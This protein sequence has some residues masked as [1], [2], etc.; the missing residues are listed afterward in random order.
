MNPLAD[1]P[2]VL[3]L[4]LSADPRAWR[5][6]S[7]ACTAQDCVVLLGEAVLLMP[8]VDRESGAGFDCRLAVSGP[9]AEARGLTADMAADGVDFVDDPGLVTL[10]ATYDRCL[11]WR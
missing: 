5:D 6:C 9:D 4:L 2:G 1:M 3:H 10:V 11:S 7:A 8:G